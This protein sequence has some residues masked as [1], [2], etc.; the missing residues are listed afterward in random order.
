MNVQNLR[1]ALPPP[2][3][4]WQFDREERN[5]VARLLVLLSDPANLRVLVDACGWHVGDLTDAEVGVE[6]TYLRDLWRHHSGA[7]PETLRAAILRTLE[8]TAADELA[9][10]SVLGF[11]THF[12]AVPSPSATFIQS[13][14]NWSVA[15]FDA[16][17]AGSSD[18]SGV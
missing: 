16:H 2:G 17:I 15:R 7:D 12:G 18:F 5:A 3:P 13:P 10:A 4:F 14:S 1:N 8:P 9:L 11:N 6:W